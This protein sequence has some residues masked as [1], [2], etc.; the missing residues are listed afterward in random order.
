M[1]EAAMGQPTEKVLGSYPRVESEYDRMRELIRINGPL[2]ER[3]I[4]LCMLSSFATRRDEASVKD[5]CRTASAKGLSFKDAEHVILLL[6]GATIG[7]SPT[8][9]MLTWVKDEFSKCS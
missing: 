9:D 3:E 8:A 4:E 5:W 7:L 2:T 6:L 1:N